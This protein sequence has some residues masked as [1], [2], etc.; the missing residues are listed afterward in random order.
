MIIAL[1]HRMPVRTLVAVVLAIY[2][3]F[4]H[5]TFKNQEAM[6]NQQWCQLASQIISLVSCFFVGL[7][8]PISSLD[9]FLSSDHSQCVCTDG[10]LTLFPMNGGTA[11]E[12]ISYQPELSTLS[13]F[14]L[15]ALS[16]TLNQS[17]F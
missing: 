12:V 17:P 15:S 16:I 14:N 4:V 3:G 2:L 6:V 10:P 13:L 5:N 8:L 11:A 9:S 7:K 1:R